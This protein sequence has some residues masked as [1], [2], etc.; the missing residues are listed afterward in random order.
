MCFL[1]QNLSHSAQNSYFWLAK[2]FK[3]VLEIP[4]SEIS[5][6]SSYLAYLCVTEEAKL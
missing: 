3:S 2:D 4:S 6:L 5:F 1:C